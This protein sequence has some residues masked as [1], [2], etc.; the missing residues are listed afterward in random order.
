VTLPATRLGYVSAFADAGCHGERADLL[1]R[2]PLS[3]MAAYALPLTAACRVSGFTPGEAYVGLVCEGLYGVRDARG[4]FSGDIADRIAT[5]GAQLI[6]IAEAW[7]PVTDE[8]GEC[9]RVVFA[10]SLSGGE[11]VLGLAEG[12]TRGLADGDPCTCAPVRAVRDKCPA[13]R[14]KR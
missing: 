5:A 11:P 4:G 7:R 13:W 9:R 12:N 14:W 3:T 10:P 2:M 6:E 1:L 8:D